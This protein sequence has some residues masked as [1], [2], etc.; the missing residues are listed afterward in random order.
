MGLLGLSKA[1]DIGGIWLDK[2]YWVFLSANCAGEYAYKAC[3]VWLGITFHKHTIIAGAAI[4][5]GIASHIVSFH[6]PICSA[7]VLDFDVLIFS[8]L[9]FQIKKEQ[10]HRI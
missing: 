4:K 5:V 10:I 8:Y 7:S 9:E 6:L 2:S 1:R 3:I